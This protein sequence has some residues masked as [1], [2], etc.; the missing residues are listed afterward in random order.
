M[1][2]KTNVNKQSF[3]AV[4]N[5]SFNT[6]NNTQV[7][8]TNTVK[9]PILKSKTLHIISK[10]KAKE[11]ETI[12]LSKYN[13]SIKK[14][15][16]IKRLKDIEKLKYNWNNN[17]ADPINKEIC[18]NILNIINEV[19]IQPKIFPTANDSIQLEYYDISD[20]NKYLEFEIFKKYIKVYH[21]SSNREENTFTINN[22]NTRQINNIIM[23]FYEINKQ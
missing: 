4:N 7:K 12:N 1:L 11:Y 22:I 3:S 20:S 14:N 10:Q 6:K 23:D 16:N 17:E 15:D 2:L 9:I 21:I 18:Y 8:F 19:I 5:R 13:Y